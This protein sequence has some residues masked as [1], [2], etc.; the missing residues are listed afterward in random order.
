MARLL[1]SAFFPGNLY[2]SICRSHDN[3]R[4]G[5]CP[6]EPLD[7]SRD[8]RKGLIGVNRLAVK[9]PQIFRKSTSVVGR[10]K[11]TGNSLTLSSK[12]S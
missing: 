2:Y 10:K 3:P 6:S 11:N 7:Y 12:K 1:F 9:Q 8:T 4:R 5:S